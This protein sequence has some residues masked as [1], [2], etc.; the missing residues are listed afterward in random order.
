MIHDFRLRSGG[1]VEGKKEW[2]KKNKNKKNKRNQEFGGYVVI[3]GLAKGVYC[4]GVEASAA[5]FFYFLHHQEEIIEIRTPSFT[6][7]FS[8]LSFEPIERA[9]VRFSAAVQKIERAMGLCK[10][11]GGVFGRCDS[12]VCV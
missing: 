4:N 9:E 2:V 5:F 1:W 6:A 8:R 11:G 10:G 3:S 7:C 12:F